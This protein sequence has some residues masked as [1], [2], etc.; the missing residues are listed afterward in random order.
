MRTPLV[1]DLG[2]AGWIR[3]GVSVSG[4]GDLGVVVL[5]GGVLVGAISMALTS[6][7]NKNT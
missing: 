4:S 6:R 5:S 3:T 7:V 1:K 2:L